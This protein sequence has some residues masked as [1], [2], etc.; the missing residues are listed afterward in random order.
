MGDSLS[1][2]ITNNTLRTRTGTETATRDIALSL[3]NKGHRPAVYSPQLGAIAEELIALGIPVSNKLA[4]LPR[5][6]IIHGHHHDVTVAAI[7]FFRDVPAI[8]VC[9]DP[10]AWYDHPPPLNRIRHF[11]A[12]D[13]LRR[14]RLLSEPW[15]PPEKVTIIPNGIDTDRFR[16]RLTPLAPTPRRALVFSNQATASNFGAQLV[17]ICSSLGFAVDVM[18]SGVSATC[19]APES[20]L[21]DY[22]GW[23]LCN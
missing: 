12:V 11:V 19:D 8:F 20:R 10:R 3:K 1:I 16:P 2:L 13:G 7:L 15:I 23:P 5:P 6:D 4:E 21:P 22:A 9:H 17:A 14:D 18:G